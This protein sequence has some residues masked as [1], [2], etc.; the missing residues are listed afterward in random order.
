AR[1]RGCTRPGCTTPGYQCQVH[2]TLTDWKNGGPTNINNLTLAC[3]P[4]NRLIENTDWTTTT[5]PTGTTEWIPPPHLDTGQTRTN[6]Y[7]HPQRNLLPHNNFPERDENPQHPQHPEHPQHP[8][9]PED[10]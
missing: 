10:P 4:D 9:H 1:D 2:H 7:H 5:H 8:Q 6:N 3:G